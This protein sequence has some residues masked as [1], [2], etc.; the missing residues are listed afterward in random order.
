MPQ[1]STHPIISDLL[2]RNT[3]TADF[4]ANRKGCHV[5][6]KISTSTSSSQIKSTSTR[7]GNHSTLNPRQVR[8]QHEWGEKS[9]MLA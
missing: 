5:S 3:R 4:Q 8:S 6:C 9:G 7:V 2:A 1:P